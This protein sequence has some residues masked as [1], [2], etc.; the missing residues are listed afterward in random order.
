[1]LLTE[2]L[3]SRKLPPLTKKAVRVILPH[4]VNSLKT[5]KTKLGDSLNGIF[6]IKKVDKGNFKT[7]RE[8]HLKESLS[9]CKVSNETREEK[10][11]ELRDIRTTFKMRTNKSWTKANQNVM[12]AR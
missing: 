9:L 8:L 3:L 4:Y 11:I 6:T 5:K 7:E 1:M 10:N 2:S 12:L